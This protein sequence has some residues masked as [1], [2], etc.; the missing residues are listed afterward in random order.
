MLHV[1]PTEVTLSVLS[2]L[3]IPSLLSLPVLS[4]QWLDFFTTNQSAIFRSAA[5][6]HEYIQSETLSLEDALSVNTGRPWAGS[7]SWKDFCYRSFQLHKNWEGNGRAVARVLSHPGLD[8]Y[9]IKV[10]EK[11]GIC[12]TTHVFGG[13]SVVHLFSNTVL[14]SLPQVRGFSFLFLFP[15]DSAGY[16][17]DC[18]QW[19][20]RCFAHCEYDNGYLVFDRFGHQGGDDGAKE[21]WRLA[22]DFS[23]EVAADAPPDGRQ[24]NMSARAAMIHYHQYA[25]LGEFRPWALLRF[26][27]FTHAVCRLAFPTLIC[28]SFQ[29]VFLHD[30]RTGSLV[31]TIETRYWNIRYVD[32][33]E[34]HVFLCRPDAVH[35]FS[36]ES[37]SEVLCI[38][39]D[40]SVRCSQRV[41]DPVLDA[42]I[43]PISVSPNVDGSCQIPVWMAAHVSRDG[44]D[45]VVLSRTHQVVFIR[46]FERI[47]LGET[48]FEQAGLV[49][50]LRPQD[51]CCYLGFEHGRV[52]VATMEGLY[53]F[54]FG[55]DLSAKA[56][57]VRP[58][59]NASARSRFISCMELTDRRIYF[60]WEDARRRQDIPMFEDAESDEE[61]II[62]SGEF[63]GPPIQAPQIGG[64]S[65]TKSVPLSTDSYTLCSFCRKTRM[66]E[67]PWVALTLL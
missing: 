31:Q 6:L 50:S 43:T 40:A 65:F 67:I 37:S 2:H 57:F 47:C 21:V 16:L 26:P 61:L 53:I 4:R 27:E 22:N 46:N 51:R 58:S 60:T 64:R 5:A 8:I 19:Y 62:T 32:V 15:L 55:P 35:V 1:L 13:L 34:R 10:D 52:C 66:S 56:A 12:I 59:K 14:W 39:A 23:I 29:C 63:Q 17:N 3:P 30:L 24:M 42:F 54:T 45:L 49:L 48:S 38:L 20:V 11:S 9:C 41:E 33:N 7:T 44:R 18:L 36:R 25:P 28:M